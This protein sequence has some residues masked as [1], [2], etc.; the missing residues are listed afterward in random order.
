[1]M[2]HPNIAR[3]LDAGT[4]DTGRPYFV[5]ELVRGVKITDYC[6]QQH[7]DTRQRL[8]LFVQVCHA[9]QHAHQ[10]GIIH[11]DLKPS[12]ILVT[13]HD[14]VPVP[15]VIDFGVAKATEGRLTALTVYTELHQFIGTPAYM[16]PEQAEMSG[17]D[18]D[19]RSDIYSLGVLLYELLTGKPPFDPQSLLR[20]GLDQ[21]RRTIREQEPPRPSTRLSTMLAAELTTLATRHGAP[22]P[23]LIHFIR[24]D[25]DWIVMKALEK[26][27]TR[28]FETANGLAQDVQRFLNNQAI[29]AR[30]PS[31][32]YRLR[33]LVRRN[34]ALCAATAA[35]VAALILGLGCSAYFFL[36]QRDALRRA[37]AAEREQAALRQQAEAGLA[38][39][40]KL[41]AMAP[42]TERFTLVGRLMSQGHFAK[43]EAL[44]NEVEMVVPQ[45]SIIYNALGEM[46]ARRGELPAA[47]T[48]YTKSVQAD[49][50]NYAAYECLA[51]LLA[52]AND[53]AAYRRLSQQ[54][55]RQFS[56]TRDPAVGASLTKACLLLPP[57]PS[58]LPALKRMME[59]AVA[60]G[61]TQAAWPDLELAAGLAEYR[62]GNFTAAL[63]WLQR[64][65]KPDDNT[66]GCV[67]AWLG[68]ALAQ[69]RLG[70]ADPARQALT[71]ALRLASARGPALDGPDWSERLAALVLEREARALIVQ[72]PGD[73]QPIR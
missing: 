70:H 26:D 17:L 65:A 23:K 69:Q 60:A 29:E 54:A 39:E 41:R 11:R 9:V 50:T 64:L 7:L 1:M 62:Q 58:D 3:V 5:M 27:R 63:E 35:V 61:A 42:L 46:H 72:E 6:D 52:H 13:L 30:P 31:R 36:Q 73:Q 12:N 44:M 37:L 49:P 32:L 53:Q 15:K 34:Q 18:I 43:A 40:R 19:T 28:R 45:S 38:L 10:K 21:M 16:S 71:Q 51:P 56:A 47:I 66:T 48:N 20:A 2:D 22:P 57:A 55:L 67:L 25:L 14:G 59:T 68:S 8:E 24:G 33:K 4:T